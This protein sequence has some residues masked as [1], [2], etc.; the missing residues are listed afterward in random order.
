MQANETNPVGQASAWYGQALAHDT[1]WIVTFTPS[2]L[3]EID[4]ALRSVRLTSLSL[5]Q[6]DRTT[7]PLPNLQ[8]K[9]A[10]HLKEIESGR[11]FVVLRGL[12]VGQV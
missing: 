10:G 5:P 2:D 9:L 6:I 3:E 1:S 12:P 11:G 7:F 4:A 8:A